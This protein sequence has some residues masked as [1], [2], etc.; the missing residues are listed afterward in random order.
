MS[1]P[2]RILVTGAAGFLGSTLV[3]RLLAEGHTVLA[4]LGANGRPRRFPP[5]V[6]ELMA[7]PLILPL[8]DHHRY[9]SVLIFEGNEDCLA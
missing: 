8:P 3:D 7:K 9:V 4:S 2:E 6:R 5:E 1:R